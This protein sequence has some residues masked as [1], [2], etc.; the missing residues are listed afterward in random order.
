MKM[1]LE[2]HDIMVT[3]EA[4]NDDITHQE[5]ADLF[6]GVLRAHGY[7]FDEIEVFSNAATFM[8][9]REDRS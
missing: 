7:I 5:A 9:D 4:D 2:M 1:S 8:A 3:V 6:A